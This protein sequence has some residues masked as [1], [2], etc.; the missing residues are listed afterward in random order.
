[1][2]RLKYFVKGFL[3]GIMVVAKLKVIERRYF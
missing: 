3:K 2:L 1:M